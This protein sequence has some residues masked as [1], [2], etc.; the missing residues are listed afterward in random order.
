[1]A[2]LTTKRS[3]K[4]W[5]TLGCE[6]VVVLIDCGASHN[7]IS[8]N[9]IVRCGLPIQ[10]TLPYMVEVE[11]GHKVRCQ[12]KCQGL[13]LE[14][15]GVQIQQDFFVFSLC[16]ADVVL[17][18]EWLATL[19]E[20]RA[21]FGNLK[22]SIGK[23]PVEHVLQGDPIL[24]KSKSNLKTLWYD[25]KQQADCYVLKWIEIKEPRVDPVPPDIL[26]VLCAH[27][28]IFKDLEGLPPP[29][30]FDHS[31]HLQPN[32]S[33]PNLWPYKYSH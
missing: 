12:G 16:G 26:D 13:T 33:I 24:S 17:G 28:D 22:L 15:Q 32:A 19:G 4:L 3:W 5:G 9:L 23:G 21:D 14:V 8:Y 27:Q 10:P 18:L 20:V 25:F 6:K 31:I 2:G 29:R 11:D 1:M 7:F 30:S